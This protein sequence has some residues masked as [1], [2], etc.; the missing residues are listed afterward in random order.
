MYRREC[1]TKTLCVKMKRRTHKMNKR[2]FIKTKEKENREI[3]KLT[4]TFKTNNK[5]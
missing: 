2:N 4:V 3:R 5:I 1:V